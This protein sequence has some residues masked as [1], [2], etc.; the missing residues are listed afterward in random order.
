M[1]SQSHEA[2]SRR[3]LLAG[4]P[5]FMS[6]KRRPNVI[7]V[8]TDDHGAWANHCYGCP[9]IQTPNI[10]RLAAGGIRFTNAYACTPVC[11]PSRAT[12]L[13]GRMPSAHGIQD[14]LYGDDVTGPTAQEF[15]KG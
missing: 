4:A 15:L 14:W 12:Y 6:V 2:L 7:F 9:D 1:P 11:S 13:T 3:S 10:D 5:A 8:L